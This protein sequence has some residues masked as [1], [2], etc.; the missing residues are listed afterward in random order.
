MSDNIVQLTLLTL[1]FNLFL[2]FYLTFFIFVLTLHAHSIVELI[3]IYIY[4]IKCWFLIV[5]WFRSFQRRREFHIDF[6]YDL[7]R[8]NLQ[9]QL[10]KMLILWMGLHVSHTHICIYYACVYMNVYTMRLLLCENAFL[11]CVY[12][13]CFITR[14]SNNFMEGKGISSDLWNLLLGIS[15]VLWNLLL[16]ISSDLWNLLLE[17]FSYLWNCCSVT[18]GIFL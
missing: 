11:L 10:T 2:L 13:W 6:S 15:S 8:F 1:L 4:G 18:Q 9:V 17:I 5:S 12:L 7:S 16:R 14:G 3:Y